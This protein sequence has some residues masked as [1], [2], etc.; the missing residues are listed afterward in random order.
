MRGEQ[1]GAERVGNLLRR[2]CESSANEIMAAI[3]SDLDEYTQGAAASDDR[4][5]L[6]L[7]CMLAM[8]D[9]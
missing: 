9:P 7:K 4:T 5:I 2:H 1:F 6:I 3:S 8:E